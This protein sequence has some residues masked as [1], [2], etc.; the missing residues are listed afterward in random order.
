[1]E[2]KREERIGPVFSRT[3]LGAVARRNISQPADAKNN[4][5]KR[6]EGESQGRYR[7]ESKLGDKRK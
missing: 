1:M 4:L 7:K 6:G 2:E 5:E 3:K